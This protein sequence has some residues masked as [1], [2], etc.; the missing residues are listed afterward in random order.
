MSAVGV[1]TLIVLF[2]LF[3][4][5]ATYAPPLQK[6]YTLLGRV[7]KSLPPQMGTALLWVVAIG[8]IGWLTWYYVPWEQ[9]GMRGAPIVVFTPFWQAAYL[10]TGALLLFSVGAVVIWKTPVKQVRPA[11]LLVLVVILSHLAWSIA[12][13]T[14][15]KPCEENDP[16]Q[17]CKT[18][19]ATDPLFTQHIVPIPDMMVNENGLMV[20][21][22]SRKMAKLVAQRFGTRIETVQTEDGSEETSVRTDCSEIVK[23]AELAPGERIEIVPVPQSHVDLNRCSFTISDITP[24]PFYEVEGERT[25]NDPS[26]AP[27]LPCPKAPAHVNVFLVKDVRGKLLDCQWFTQNK[28][29]IAMENHNKPPNVESIYIYHAYNSSQVGQPGSQVGLVRGA[30]ITFRLTKVKLEFVG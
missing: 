9:F 10:I 4:L 12:V 17:Q 26:H 28:R 19:L 22:Q 14:F 3:V 11:L 23:V 5:A 1:I 24:P 30:T 25:V 20:P 8:V 15:A 13:S 6:A 21:K 2:A 7:F 16:R 29:V 18:E 27:L